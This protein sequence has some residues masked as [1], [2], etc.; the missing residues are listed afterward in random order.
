MK[1]QN[2][3]ASSFTTEKYMIVQAGAGLIA[4]SDKSLALT[5]SAAFYPFYG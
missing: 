1:A 3:S 4:L 2:S 5:F